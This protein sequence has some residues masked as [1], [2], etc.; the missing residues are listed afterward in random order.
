MKVAK[1]PKGLT[2]RKVCS[3]CGRQRAEHG[4]FGFGNKCPLTTCG[5]CG[6]DA[7]C[8]QNRRVSMG[9]TCTL[10]ESDGAVAG[11][12]KKYEAMLA[13]LAARAEIR[14]ELGRNDED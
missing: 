5:K 14:A 12:P 7:Q 10:T 11:F 13:D 9:V 4:E 8:H 1:L 2:F 3:S 6:A